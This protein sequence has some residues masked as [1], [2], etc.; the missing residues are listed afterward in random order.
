MYSL[1]PHRSD[2]GGK[3]GDARLGRK[4]DKWRY[5]IIEDMG[6]SELRVVQGLMTI[7]PESFKSLLRI[8]LIFLLCL[9]STM[10]PSPGS[11]ASELL[12][13]SLSPTAPAQH[14]S[15]TVCCR[16]LAFLLPV[17]SVQF[18]TRNCIS[19]ANPVPASKG[20][21]HGRQWAW[22]ALAFLGSCP[23]SCSLI[24]SFLSFA[25]CSS[26]RVCPLLSL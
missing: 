6:D 21:I 9:F 23:S 17:C 10:E 8:P 22:Q 20:N 3:S 15:P 16:G 25:P 4:G 2:W 19:S 12:V 24:L 5:G 13:I 7:V 1:H 18:A 14:T 26:I 11:R